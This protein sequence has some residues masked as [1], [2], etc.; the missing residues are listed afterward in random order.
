MQVR[1]RGGSLETTPNGGERASAKIFSKPNNYF[2]SRSYLARST[3]KNSSPDQGVELCLGANHKTRSL[4]CGG[5]R[6]FQDTQN[7]TP[8]VFVKLTGTPVPCYRL[9]GS[10]K[11]WLFVLLS[12][13][14]HIHDYRIFLLIWRGFEITD[15]CG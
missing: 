1:C 5:A 11:E 12:N 14:V 15:F 8:E 9:L 2:V 3:E 10:R 7:P 6:E 4:L 13:R